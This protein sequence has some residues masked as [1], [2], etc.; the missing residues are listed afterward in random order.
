VTEGVRRSAAQGECGR[1]AND[2]C[3]DATQTVSEDH[4][5]RRVQAVGAD[6]DRRRRRRDRKTR[7]CE[8]GAVLWGGLL[9][10]EV[11]AHAAGALDGYEPG[12]DADGIPDACEADCN[13]NGTPDDC[14]TFA[15]CNSN[16]T[17]DECDIASETSLDVNTNGVPDECEGASVAFCN[18]A[19]GA[20][21]ACPCA[22]PGNPDSGCDIAQ[23]TGGVRLDLQ[24]QQ[25][26]P[27]N[28]TTVTG[29]GFPVAG[30]PTAIV[31]RADGLDPAGPVVFGDGLRCIGTSIVRLAATFASGGTSTHVFGHGAGAGPGTFYYQLW[32]RNTP[33]MYCDPG[34]AF[35]LSNGRT[36]TW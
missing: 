18:D 11:E 9:R 21:S 23:G 19:D 17:P 15:D 20:L 35:N 5:P 30:A 2:G 13:A 26:S 1:K 33:I 34:A 29:T 27:Q 25:T 3:S 24:T 28:R 7:A 10:L 4:P 6:H 22:N 36:M 31:I 12:C 14:E 16:G 8:R 32:F